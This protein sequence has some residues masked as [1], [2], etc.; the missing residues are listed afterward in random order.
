MPLGNSLFS[1]CLERVMK[2]WHSFLIYYYWLA[3]AEVAWLPGAEVAWLPGAEVA[4]IPGAG[5]GLVWTGG[6]LASFTPGAPTVEDHKD[7]L[8]KAL[9]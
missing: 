8:L 2:H 3:G 5:V 6:A 9:Q 7:I 4:S 1:R